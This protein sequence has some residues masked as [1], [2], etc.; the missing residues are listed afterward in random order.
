VKRFAIFDLVAALAMI[1]LFAL[2]DPTSA[3]AAPSSPCQIKATVPLTVKGDKAIVTLSSNCSGL[4]GVAIY[5][6]PAPKFDLKTADQQ[7]FEGVQILAFEANKPQ[8]V[9]V[10]VPN[11]YFQVDAFT[12][13]VIVKLSPTNLYGSRL[14][15][16]VSGGSQPCAKPTTTTVMPHPVTTTTTVKPH[17]SAPVTT[18]IQAPEL[19]TSEQLAS[20]GSNTDNLTALGVILFTGGLALALIGRRVR[21]AA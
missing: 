12:G 17:L 6:A 13:E 9:T 7:T 1:G 15:S 4:G 2:I 8:T 18:T 14:V 19:I 16:S 10:I 21:Q 20:T 3:S 11:C 5:G